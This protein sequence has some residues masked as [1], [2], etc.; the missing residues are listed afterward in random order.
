M[1]YFFSLTCYSNKYNKNSLMNTYLKLGLCSVVL[2]VNLHHNVYLLEHKVKQDC[3]LIE[4]H[5]EIITGHILPDRIMERLCIWEASPV[6]SPPDRVIFHEGSIRVEALHVHYGSWSSPSSQSVLSPLTSC[7][8]H[9]QFRLQGPILDKSIR[10]HLC[11]FI[12][13]GGSRERK[14]TQMGFPPFSFESVQSQN[15][16]VFG[17]IPSKDDTNAFGEEPSP[18]APTTMLSYSLSHSTLTDLPVPHQQAPVLL[19]A[20]PWCVTHITWV[21]LD[22]N[23]FFFLFPSFIT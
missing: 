3:K 5:R 6:F 14:T 7:S 17:H 1:L 9:H 20:T 2:L 12:S 23:I 4:Q 8:T 16:D 13:H 11:L 21:W 19:E 18:I 15:I 22:H 10:H